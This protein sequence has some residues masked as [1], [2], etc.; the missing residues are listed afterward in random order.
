M[1]TQVVVAIVNSTVPDLVDTVLKI[2]FISYLFC[3][4]CKDCVSVSLSVSESDLSA[5]LLAN[6]TLKKLLKL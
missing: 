1:L 3:R 2:Y 5:G 6:P 4:W